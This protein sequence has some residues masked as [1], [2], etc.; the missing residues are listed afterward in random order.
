MP[1]IIVTTDVIVIALSSKH[2]QTNKQTIRGI[3]RQTDRQMDRY[4]T[5]R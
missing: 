4:I 5:N 3:Y 2:N 1:F